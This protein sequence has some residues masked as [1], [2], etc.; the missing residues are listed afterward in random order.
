LVGNGNSGN[1]EEEN[2]QNNPALRNEMDNINAASMIKTIFDFLAL[3]L[4]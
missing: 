1:E 2:N 3:D 4:V